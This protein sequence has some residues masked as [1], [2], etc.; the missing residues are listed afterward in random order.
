MRPRGLFQRTPQPLPPDSAL[1]L[2]TEGLVERP[3]TDIEAQID[4]VARTLKVKGG[5]P[6][7]SR[8]PRLTVTAG[9]APPS[10]IGGRNL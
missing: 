6:S 2:C 1:A 3:G 8:P 7:R 5:C 10:V 4:V 9:G